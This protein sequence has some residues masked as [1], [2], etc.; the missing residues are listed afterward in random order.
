MLTALS[1]AA[2]LATGQLPPW[3]TGQSQPADLSISL[4]TFSPGDTL[5][6]WWGHTALVVEDRRLNHARLYNFG[7]FSFGEGFVHRFVQGRLE[8]W[9]A[10]DSV[11]AT[12]NLYRTLNRDVRIQELD[13]LPEQAANIAKALGTHVLPENR[14][15]LYHHYNDN[16]ST[17]PRDIL[18]AAIG[19]QLKAATRAPARMSLRE[20]TRRYSMVN[21]PMS[22]VLD[23]LQNDELDGPITQA[24]EAFLP[25]ELEQQVQALQLTGTDGVKRPL[26]RKQWTWFKANRPPVPQTPPNWIPWLL[27]VGLGVAGVGQLLGWAA[28]SGRRLPRVLL[29][30]IHVLLGLGLGALGVFLFIVGIFTNHTVAHRNENL[31]LVNPITFALLPLGVMLMWGAKKARPALFWTWAALGALSLL[32]VALKVLPMFDQQNWNLIALFAPINVGFAAL[33]WLD[34]RLEEKAARPT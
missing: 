6:E 12:Y 25:D 33:F 34:R 16:C 20:Q 22:L 3:M 17:R 28:R 26:V 8:F 24:H 9:V 29:G 32:G 7:M 19:G 1:L 2:A 30:L 5:T 15:Y 27:L 18:D 11:G 14:T 31:L 21:P 4:V 10:D 23:Y 13:L